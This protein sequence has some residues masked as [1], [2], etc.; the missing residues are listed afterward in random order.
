MCIINRKEQVENLIQSD[1]AKELVRMEEDTKSFTR[2]RKIKLPD[3]LLKCLDNQGLTTTMELLRFEKKRGKD[4][5]EYSKEAY[6]N[7]RRHLNPE[8]FKVAN[9]EFLEGFYEEG[10][11]QD[12]IYDYNGYFILALDGSKIE[13]PNIPTNREYFGYQTNQ[14]ENPKAR[15]LI[16]GLY[17]SLNGFYIDIKLGNYNTK[18]SDLAKENI[19]K[20]IDIIGKERFIIVFDRNYPSISFINYLEELGI[21]YVIRMQKNMYLKE[22]KQVGEDGWTDLEFTCNRLAHIQDNEERER[23]RDKKS[24][25]VRITRVRLEKEDEWLISNVEE[26]ITK[27]NLKEIYHLRWKVE[28][29]FNSLKNKLHLESFSGHSPIIIYQDVYASMLLY[30]MIHDIKRVADI[31]VNNDGK[32]KYKYKINENQAIGLYKDEFIKLFTL[33]DK[34]EAVRLFNRIM[35]EIGKYL[36]PIREGRKSNPRNFNRTNKYSSNMKRSY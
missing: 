2:T 21:K 35:E 17:D 30:N 32:K 5:V 25:K 26:E 20:A 27:D 9:K 8:F 10:N 23:L 13:V 6:L 33:D 31:K 14:G 22:K 28:E 24:V 16:T 29:G 19:E 15:A 34:K 18:E 12:V 3:L 4:K 36:V 11:D 1:R 7:K